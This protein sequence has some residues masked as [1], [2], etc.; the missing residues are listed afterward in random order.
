MKIIAMEPLGVSN[1]VLEELA[2]PFRAAGHEFI[3]YQDRAASDEALIERI[4]DAEILILANQPLREKVLK[5]CKALKMISIGFTGVDHVD[6]AYCRERGIVMCN[7]AGYSTNAVAEL[8]FG[9]M[10]SA[11]RFIPAC[12]KAARAL[13]DKTGLV[14]WELHGKTLGII[15]TGA[16]GCRVAEIGKA[17]G[18]RLIAWSRS[19]KQAALDLGVEYMPLEQVLKE[20]DILSLHVPAT[21]ETKGLIGKAELAMMKPTAILINTARGPVVDTAALKEALDAGIIAGA[22]LDVFDTEPPLPESEPLLSAK[23]TVLTPHVAF[24]TE[25]AMYQR[26]I[27]IFEN[28]R[29]YELKDPQN[30]V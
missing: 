28:V 26:A 7:A 15:G 30:L 23:N 17:F 22:G 2:A 11:A 19:E 21:P 4:K 27:I 12:D 20:S 6:T 13:K 5:E 10:L 9:L 25:E 29:R 14:G 18:C 24:A 8:A 16:I 1:S 3:Y